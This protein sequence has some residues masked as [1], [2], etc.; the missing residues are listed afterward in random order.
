M[1]NKRKADDHKYVAKKLNRDINNIRFIGPK[2]ADELFNKRDYIEWSLEFANKVY[3]NPEIIK[4]IDEL[5]M[6]TKKI[7]AWNLVRWHGDLITHFGEELKNDFDVAR[8]A[9]GPDHIEDMPTKTEHRVISRDGDTAEVQVYDWDKLKTWYNLFPELGKD[10]QIKILKGR[11]LLGLKPED[12]K[13]FIGHV[14]DEI[15]NDPEVVKNIIKDFPFVYV[16]LDENMKKNPDIM[17]KVLDTR[18]ADATKD[19]FAKMTKEETKKVLSMYR[20]GWYGYEIPDA[21]K[22]AFKDKEYLFA[23]LENNKFDHRVLEMMDKELLNDPEVAKTCLEKLDIGYG[24][25]AKEFVNSF[26]KSTFDKAENVVSFIKGMGY[27]YKDDEVSR[28]LVNGLSIKEFEKA[29]NIYP[30]VIGIS[31]TQETAKLISKLVK[32]V[33]EEDAVNF[34]HAVGGFDKLTVEEQREIFA[35][36]PKVFYRHV[37]NQDREFF[38]EAAVKNPEVIDVISDDKLRADVLI[39]Y[40]TIKYLDKKHIKIAT[41]AD[42]D[43]LIEKVKGVKKAA[44]KTAKV[45]K[46]K[47]NKPKI[48]KK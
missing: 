31:T 42:L 25:E 21:I 46:E 36:N 1:F 30:Y 39:E 4:T 16:D 17:V 18:Y 41:E 32:N 35:R 12:D 26:P 22:F 11:P 6:E 9:I 13:Y 29:A 19:V 38:V 20:V 15:K 7:I 27:R 48:T 47:E 40:T 28:D 23:I 14:P 24:V 34:T 45:T 43:K 44:T 10:A 2:G 3:E 5:P 33:K 8:E 37:M